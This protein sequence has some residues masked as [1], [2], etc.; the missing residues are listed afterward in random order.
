MRLLCIFVAAKIGLDARTTRLC[1]TQPP[2]FAKRLRRALAP[3][4]H[5]PVEGSRVFPQWKARPAF[6]AR[7]DAAA[8]TASHPNVGDDRDTPSEGTG[9]GYGGDLGQTG[10]EKF[11]LRGLDDQISETN[12]L[13]CASANRSSPA[14][15]TGNQAP[16]ESRS[17]NSIA[18]AVCRLMVARAT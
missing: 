6:S 14:A 1:R 3:F 18:K 5:A 7:D 9:R 15:A 11:L 16:S 10:N 12:I 2:V 4:V 8:S 17:I 13:G